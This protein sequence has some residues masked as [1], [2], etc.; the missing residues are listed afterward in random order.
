MAER[1][2]AR[3]AICIPDASHAVPVSY[4]GATAQLI[5]EAAALPVAA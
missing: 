1:A 3:T 2:G 5:L 4:P